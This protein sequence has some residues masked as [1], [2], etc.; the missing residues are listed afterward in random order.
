M[1]PSTEV[2]VLSHSQ[3]FCEQI[4]LEEG[5]SSYGIYSPKQA[6]EIL[7]RALTRKAQEGWQLLTVESPLLFWRSSK[8]IF[9]KT[10][11]A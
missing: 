11:S 1:N 6:N 4:S 3:L 8:Y 7:S 9:Q 10:A 2:I 5:K